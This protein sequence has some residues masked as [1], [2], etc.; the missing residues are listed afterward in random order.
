MKFVAGFFEQVSSYDWGFPGGTVVKN[1]PANSGF[2][3]WVRKIPW[4]KKR[5]PTPVFLPERFMGR[6]AWR[7]TVHGVAESQTPL[8]H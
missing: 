4:R 7:A 8:N 6:E 5:Q 1:L 3:P 2:D